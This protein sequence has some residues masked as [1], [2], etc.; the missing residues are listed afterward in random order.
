[1][2]DWRKSSFSSVAGCIE[3]GQAWV[4]AAASNS[5]GACVEV[6]HPEVQVIKV[7]DTKDRSGPQLAFSGN[8]WGKFLDR[9]KTREWG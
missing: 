3:V 2:S 1:M 4:K 7:R 8:T 9:V 5:Q 6:Q